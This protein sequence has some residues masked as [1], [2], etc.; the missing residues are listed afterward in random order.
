[1]DSK[2]AA[3]C[4]P[5]TPG[6]WLLRSAHNGQYPYCFSFL[7]A[8]EQGHHILIDPGS[9]GES[10]TALKQA[11]PIH[12]VLFSHSHPDHMARARL[13]RGA[14]IRCPRESPEKIHDIDFL[15][16]RATGGGEAVEQWK[17]FIEETAGSIA[18]PTFR[19]HD[20]GEFVR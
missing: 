3:I 9:D 11:V 13:F 8:G 16:M 5:I 1:M 20:Q 6:I 17:Q 2:L 19:R 15:A 10:L 12:E 4:D 7:V 14:P 18:D